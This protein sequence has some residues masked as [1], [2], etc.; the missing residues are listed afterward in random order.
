ME[1]VYQQTVDP[2]N[3]A[4]QMF[5]QMMGI[6]VQAEL[7]TSRL[8]GEYMSL[9]RALKSGEVTLAELNVGENGFSVLPPP[10]VAEIEPVVESNGKKGK[11]KVPA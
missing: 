1:G 4:S 9:L 6:A 3:I 7:Q 8:H 2:T 11:A 5:Q 10:P